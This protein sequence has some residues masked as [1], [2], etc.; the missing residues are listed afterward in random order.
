MTDSDKNI[1]LHISE[2]ALKSMSSLEL[3]N[4]FKSLVWTS[5]INQELPIKLAAKEGPG[6]ETPTTL[7]RLFLHKA[8]LMKD[9]ICMQAIREKFKETKDQAPGLGLTSKP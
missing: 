7:S 5:D 9:Q 8:A 2:D 3:R 4:K 1:T 6:S